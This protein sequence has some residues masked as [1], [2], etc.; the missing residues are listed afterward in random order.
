[1]VPHQLRPP[2]NYDICD[3]LLYIRTI[4]IESEISDILRNLPFDRGWPIY[5][6][7]LYKRKDRKIN[8]VNISLPNGIKPGGQANF[9][10]T[11][12]AKRIEKIIFQEFCLI[13]ERFK[14]LTN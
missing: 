5:V 14:K 13:L 2:E 8:P 11:I 12:K 10:N 6:N 1:M 3:D 4:T 9:D 7:A